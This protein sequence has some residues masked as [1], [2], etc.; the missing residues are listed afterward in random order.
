MIVGGGLQA[1][2]SKVF[3]ITAIT[4]DTDVT[5]ARAQA[6]QYSTS[7]GLG[8]RDLHRALLNDEDHFARVA[9]V[10]DQG[11]PPASGL[12]SQQRKRGNSNFEVQILLV[13][14]V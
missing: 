8:L 10:E 12:E 14:C 2:N 6:R 5:I 11:F 1:K 4:V 3:E 7:A 13:S 9:L